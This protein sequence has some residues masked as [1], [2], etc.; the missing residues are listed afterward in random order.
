M[1]LYTAKILLSK[2]AKLISLSYRCFL[3]SLVV[4]QPNLIPVLLGNITETI[5]VIACITF[6]FVNE[7]KATMNEKKNMDA[8]DREGSL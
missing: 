7:T 2:A 5:K 8:T 4:P 6:D 1:R 3:L